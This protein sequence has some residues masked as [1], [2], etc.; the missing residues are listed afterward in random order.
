MNQHLIPKETLTSLAGASAIF[1]RLV[2]AKL[3]PVSVTKKRSERTTIQSS[4][5]VTSKVPRTLTETL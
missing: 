1:P 4:E 2:T 5:E 3:S